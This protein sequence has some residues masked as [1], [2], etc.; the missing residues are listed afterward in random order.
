MT[1]Y[2]GA[3]MS[4]ALSPD[5]K[6]GQELVL[7]VHDECCFNSHEGM[8]TIWV[9]KGK[10]PL[11]PKGRGRSYMVSEFLCQCHGHLELNAE[12]MLQLPIGFQFRIAQRTLKPGAGAEGYWMGEHVVKQLKE[13][14]IAIF[15]ILHPGKQALFMFDNSSNHNVFAPDALL[16]GKMNLLN[17]GAGKTH[18]TMRDGSHSGIPQPMH[19]DGMRKRYSAIFS[20]KYLRYCTTSG[21]S[22]PST[23]MPFLYSHLKNP[24]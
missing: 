10:T 3:D 19:L 8:S 11:R 16:C 17:G 12:Q 14:A 4:D 20:T 18:S 5:P 23:Y 13:E 9:E 22:C 7:V 6:H 1:E 24:S 21:R 2:I 15:D